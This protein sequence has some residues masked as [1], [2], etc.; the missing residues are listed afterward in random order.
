MDLKAVRDTVRIIQIGRVDP[1]AALEHSSAAGHSTRHPR[2]TSSEREHTEHDQE[3]AFPFADRLLVILL[4][5]IELP[6][7]PDCN[8]VSMLKYLKAA[9]VDT[10]PSSLE[11]H[12]GAE[13]LL[14]R[15][16]EWTTG[17]ERGRGESGSARRNPTYFNTPEC[18]GGFLLPGRVTS[19]LLVTKKFASK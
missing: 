19:G 5:W 10:Q 9:A 3:R 12:R 17:V 1:V 14:G 4:S 8:P 16:A 11:K 15:T 13:V 2:E 6:E 18:G 7:C